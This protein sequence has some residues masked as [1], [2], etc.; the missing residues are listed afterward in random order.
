MSTG[1]EEEEKGRGAGGARRSCACADRQSEWEAEL[2]I[3]NPM[4]SEASRWV[5]EVFVCVKARTIL[6]A[7]LSPKEN[8]KQRLPPPLPLFTLLLSKTTCIFVAR[9][10]VITDLHFLSAEFLRAERE[11]ERQR[12]R[13]SAGTKCFRTLFIFSLRRAGNEGPCV[14]VRAEASAPV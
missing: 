7:A 2:C 5:S 6:S 8:L 9:L 12:E 3:I 13:A 4:N 11:R 10:G 14:G 1:G